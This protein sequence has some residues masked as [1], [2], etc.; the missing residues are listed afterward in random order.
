MEGRSP[1]LAAGEPAWRE[2]TL[3]TSKAF[4]ENSS[5]LITRPKPR[6]VPV[7]GAGVDGFA[8]FSLEVEV[9]KEGEGEEGVSGHFTKICL[10]S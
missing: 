8:L 4:S 1:A 6:V 9:G 3:M 10:E 7:V 2:T 5:N